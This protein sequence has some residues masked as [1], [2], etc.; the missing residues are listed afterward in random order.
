MPEEI[1]IQG[2]DKR[3]HAIGPSNGLWCVV[4]TELQKQD[5]ACNVPGY[6]TSFE[7]ANEAARKLNSKI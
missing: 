6:Y 2:P 7:D 3:F 5:V 4:D 1:E